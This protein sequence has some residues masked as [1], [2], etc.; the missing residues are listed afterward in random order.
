MKRTISALFRQAVDDSPERLWLF[1]GERTYSYSQAMDEI[2]RAASALRAAGVGPG[3]RVLVTARNTD[4]Y[5]LSW[6]AL[7]EVGA[8]QVPLNP[9]SSAPSSRVSCS[10]PP[11]G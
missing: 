7:M 11:R 10:R 8:V 1:A 9:K 3:D 5:L 2:E 6:F 4:K